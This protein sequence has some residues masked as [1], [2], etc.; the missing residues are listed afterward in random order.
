[1]LFQASSRPPSRR[2]CLCPDHLSVILGL[3]HVPLARCEQ[4]AFANPRLVLR[5]RRLQ[6][7]SWHPLRQPQPSNPFEYRPEQVTGDRH[8]RHLE[9][10]VKSMLDHLCPDL[11]QLLLPPSRCA[12]RST[13]REDYYLRRTL[14]RGY[15]GRR[16]TVL[17]STP[18]S[19]TLT[20]QFITRCVFCFIRLPPEAGPGC[21]PTPAPGRYRLC[22]PHP[23]RSQGTRHR[24]PEETMNGWTSLP[25][26]PSQLAQ[27]DFFERK[28]NETL[29]LSPRRSNGYRLTR[30]DIARRPADPDN[31]SERAIWLAWNENRGW[32]G[33]LPADRD[34]R[35]IKARRYLS[36]G[37]A[38]R[39]GSGHG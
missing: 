32:S 8:L 33:P 17:V 36:S 25:R 28:Y 15:A 27:D 9:D 13:F 34:I 10:H 29:E 26:H 35:H 31:C 22:L 12:R 37:E 30:S 2:F 23:P 38:G 3:Q 11:D 6:S 5:V 18:P 21:G 20:V 16:G 14:P 39:R 1:M 7:S 19:P 24:R 4:T